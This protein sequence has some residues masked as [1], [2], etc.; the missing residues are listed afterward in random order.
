MEE[1]QHVDQIGEDQFEIMEPPACFVNHSCEPNVA[2]REQ[3]G[4]A[5]RDIQDGEELTIDYDMIGSFEEPF[6]CRCGA[7]R[8]RGIVQ[9]GQRS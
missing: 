5:L 9:G 4:Y 8:C 7:G 2:E 6:V 1:K 3:T